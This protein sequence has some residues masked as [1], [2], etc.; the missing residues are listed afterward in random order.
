MQFY[1][2][3][4][5]VVSLK[6]DI[7]YKKTIGEIYSKIEENAHCVG[8]ISESSIGIPEL[9]I[10]RKYNNKS[11]IKKD[12]EKLKPEIKSYMNMWHERASRGFC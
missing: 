5:V 8:T 7:E 9:Q 1:E 2:T 11:Y 3:D 12:F 6:Y 4:K 10:F